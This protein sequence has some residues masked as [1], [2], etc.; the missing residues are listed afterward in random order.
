MDLGMI[1][2][3]R[4]GGPMSQRLMRG[5]HCVIGFARNLDALRHL[6]EKG[7]QRRVVS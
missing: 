4:M 6:K 3:G 7:I 1:G 5:G 2:M